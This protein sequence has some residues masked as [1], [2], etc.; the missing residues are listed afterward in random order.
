MTWHVGNPQKSDSR[1]VFQSQKMGAGS[2][3]VLTRTLD[4]AASMTA[5]HTTLTATHGCAQTGRSPMGC[6][7]FT[8][9]TTALASIRSTCSS[10]ATEITRLTWCRR[11]VTAPTIRP[12][13]VTEHRNLLMP[14]CVRSGRQ[15]SRAASWQPSSASANRPCPWFVAA[16]HGPTWS[17]C[18][19]AARRLAQ[20]VLDFSGGAA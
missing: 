9:A 10:V 12:E 13:S 4:M 6:S 2:G 8:A 14:P 5:R 3:S 17:R 15:P 7:Y 20:D 18:E 1:S 11:G 19:I 16:G